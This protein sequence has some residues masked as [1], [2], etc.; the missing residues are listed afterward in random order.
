MG[1]HYRGRFDYIHGIHSFDPAAL[2]YQA[3]VCGKTNMDQVVVIL[4]ISV[5]YGAVWQIRQAG[6]HIFP[7]LT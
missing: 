1:I 4:H 6:I 3:Y 7:V 5:Q 2:V